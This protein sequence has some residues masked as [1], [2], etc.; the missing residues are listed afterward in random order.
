MKYKREDLINEIIRMRIEKGASTK[1]IV[2]DFLQGQLKY[3]HSY[4]YALLK[5][6][7]EKISEIYKNDNLNAINEQV[8][9]L[10]SLYEKALK[11]GNKK[12]ALEVMKEINKLCGLYAAEKVDITTGGNQINEIK[13]IEVKSENFRTKDND[14]IQ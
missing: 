3:K 4:S 1:T 12:L 14:G 8:G 11:E 5:E 9:R 7:R 6:A 2:E 13:I 10:E